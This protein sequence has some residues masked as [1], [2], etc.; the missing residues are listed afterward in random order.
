M[1]RGLNLSFHRFVFK[2]SH[3]Q[4]KRD[5]LLVLW[6]DNLIEPHAIHKHTTYY[7]RELSWFVI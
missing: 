1:N 5:R 6:T 2:M 7:P 4:L 3:C